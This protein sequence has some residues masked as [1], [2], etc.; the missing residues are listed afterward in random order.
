MN[1]QQSLENLRENQ[2]LLDALEGDIERL[3]LEHHLLN[4]GMSKS[5]PTNLYPPNMPK[6]RKNNRHKTQGA[7]GSSNANRKRKSC[8]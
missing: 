4:H 2:F 3:S 8:K 5:A 7:F 6:D 1:H